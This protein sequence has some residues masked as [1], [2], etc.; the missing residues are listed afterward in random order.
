MTEYGVQ[1][2]KIISQYRQLNNLGYVISDDE[3]V[4]IMQKEMERTGKVYPG[5]EHLAKTT[6]AAKKETDNTYTPSPIAPAAQNV[7]GNGF[8]QGKDKGL[9]LEHTNTACATIQPTLIQLYT[10]NFLKNILKEGNAIVTDR[11]SEAGIMSGLVNLWQEKFN[12]E[13]S[14]SH[15]RKTLF[16]TQQDLQQME[17]AARGEPISTNFLGEPIYQTFEENFKS[18]RGVEFNAENITDCA[19]KSETYAQIKTAVEMVNKTKESLLTTTKGD[20]AS[21]MSPEESSKAIIQAFKLAGVT[22][23]NEIN[24]TLADINEKYKDHPDVLKYG[25]NFRIN[26]NKQGEY[27]IYRTDKSGYPAEATNEELRLIANEMSQRLDRTL[28]DA[29]GVEY[30]KDTTSEEMISL[31]QKKLKEYQDVYEESFKKA[32]GSRDLK[33]LSE[34][35]VA[36]Q[37]QGVATIEMGI[38]LL[39]TA[40][41]IL[42]PVAVAARGTALGA[43]LGLASKA[44]MG[45]KMIQGLETAQ[46]VSAPIVMAAMTLRPTELLEQISSQNGMSAEEWEAWGVGVLQNSVY[47]VTGMKVSQVA[48]QGAAMYKTKALVNTLKKAGKS[49]DE[50]I[51]M[52]KANP[53]KFPDDIV[54]SFKNI[55]KLAKTLQVTSEVALDLSSTYFLN[56]VMNNGDLQLQDWISSIAFAI[57]GGVLQKQFAPLTTAEKVQ[58]LC[59]AFKD[60][61]VTPNDAIN[62]LK[63][64]DDI[65]EGKI[66][67]PSKNTETNANDESSAKTN[68]QTNANLATQQNS[69]NASALED[70]VITVSRP[71]TREQVK[72][73]SIN[74]RIER[75]NSREEFVS[76]RDE[77]KNM[78]EGAEKKALQEEYLKKYNEW[79]Q[80]SQRPEIK[81]Q[82]TPEAS[83]EN[84]VKVLK[85]LGANDKQI[86]KFQENANDEIINFIQSRITSPDFNPQNENYFIYLKDFNLSLIQE[87]AANPQFPKEQLA[88]VA[89]AA[90]TPNFTNQLRNA[91]KNGVDIIPGCNR[92]IKIKEAQEAR[93][94]D[95]AVI[96]KQ[97]AYE[98]GKERIKANSSLTDMDIREFS[99]YANIREPAI[100]DL[101]IFCE[102]NEIKSYHNL[103]WRCSENRAGDKLT[104]EEI[105]ARVRFAQKGLENNLEPH[106]ITSLLF[107]YEK[108]SPE[109]MENRLNTEI[110]IKRQENEKLNAKETAIKN[111]KNSLLEKYNTPELRDVIEKIITKEN[112][113]EDL[114][115]NLD[116]IL[117]ENPNR[118]ACIF[119][120]KCA[121]EIK[122]EE[123]IIE[124]FKRDFEAGLK[125]P[126][127]TS[128]DTK[129]QS[130][131]KAK[132]VILTQEYLSSLK[133]EDGKPVFNKRAVESLITK[134]EKNPELVKEV[135]DMAVENAGL[136]APAVIE[137]LIEA[138]AIDKDMAFSIISMKK[139]NGEARFDML[140]LCFILSSFKSKFPLVKEAFNLEKVY[141]MDVDTSGLILRAENVTDI[142]TQF[143]YK[144]CRILE[145]MKKSDGSPMYHSYWDIQEGILQGL[146]D[147]P[148]L[149]LYYLKKNV[150][151]E[152]TAFDGDVIQA[153]NKIAQKTPDL[154]KAFRQELENIKNDENKTQRDNFISKIKAFSKI[155]NLDNALKIYENRE[156][157]GLNNTLLIYV[158][159]KSDSIPY[160]NIV[161]IKE[162][163][164]KERI[165]ELSP[166]D[167]FLAI[168][169]SHLA[170]AKSINEIPME[171]KKSLLRRLVATNTDLFNISDSLAK[172]FPL[173][174]RNQEQYCELLPALVRSLGIE[175]VKLTPQKVE[176]FNTSIDN[177]SQ[178]IAKIPDSDFANLH[179]TQEYSKDDFIKTVLEKVKDLPHIERQKVF[180]YYG[181]ELKA[182]KGNKNTGYSINGYPVNLNNGKK[183]AE[184]TDSKTQAVVESLREDVIR[185]TENNRIKCENPTVE[186]FLNEIVEDL[187]EIRTIIGKMQH[188]TH[189]YDVMQHSLKVM[190]KIAQ[191]PQFKTLNKSDQKIMLLASLMHDI[192]K[193]EGFSDKTHANNG[194]FDTFYIA[195]KFNLTSEEEIKLYTIIRH[196]EWLEHVNK[197]TNEYD[198]TKRLQSTA[199]D[200][201]QDNLFDMALIFTHADLKA[202]KYNNSFHDSTSG[203]INPRFNEE[204]RVFDNE[205]GTPISLGNAAD[206]YAKRIKIYINELK[207]SI[208]LTPVTQVP[209]SDVIK[210]HIK[211]INPDGST[212]HKGVYVDKDGL[213]VIKFNEVTDWEALGFPKGT[214][215][216]GIAGTGKVRDNRS[217]VIESEFDTGNFK[218]YAHAL[219]YAN[220][221]VKFDSFGLPDSDVLLSVTYMERPESKYRN[222]RTQGIGL[223]IKSKYVY[224]GG[225]TDAGSGC[226][227]TIKEFKDNYI[228]GGKREKDRVF[229][230]NLIKKATGMT[231]A[232]YIEFVTKNQ[233]K[234]W[235][236]IEPIDNS[237]PVEFRNKLI[238]AFG[239][240]IVSNQRAQ[241]RAYDEYYASNPEPPM[242]TWAY[243][244]DV[245]ETI[246]NPLDFLH[247][248]EMTEA[249]RK[250]GQVGEIMLTSV[251]ERTEFLR[252]YSLENNISFIVFGD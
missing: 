107:E 86:N 38:N 10:I 5:F 1:Q 229:T 134:G 57:S 228:F 172:D 125:K 46:K 144:Y 199:F 73:P 68:E 201:Q 58:Y 119:L 105:D 133:D 163:L 124:K 189:K 112:L 66:K 99:N 168:E 191:D 158:L 39:S 21:Q 87:I 193:R 174:P 120:E 148:E 24:K 15:V 127:L 64:M 18:R 149:T 204:E 157:L 198:L 241:K 213:V 41:M 71:S 31:T 250:I 154:E 178:T 70:V 14:K 65:S 49:T 200:L 6:S 129:W 67:V 207:K 211:R 93:M 243:S 30:S 203:I 59:D 247:R 78:A 179:I 34:E 26:K 195:K 42:P 173:I 151:D 96:A 121:S 171:A 128:G 175:T 138:A 74:E 164:G 89:N 82:N 81:M 184:I 23:V 208:P 182:N 187:P 8:Y 209:K 115:N 169:F 142:R 155:E 62:I 212:E 223:N 51:S 244:A 33:I 35:Y 103:L 141:D 131:P 218:F 101:I 132:E 85:Q 143:S 190:Q 194:S 94:N 40:L 113:P 63:T 111:K 37:Q 126:D 222:Y 196:H 202:V 7:F 186:K 237:D 97:K 165:S 156:E 159:E 106:E 224:G 197:S 29:I 36:K 123:F 160:E 72:E 116:A 11:D 69:K 100:Q 48:E 76:L 122:P 84:V 192:T 214:T 47:M 27:V 55:D 50:I 109:E 45:G 136:R 25:G 145:N 54:K 19:E 188:D 162:V 252:Q 226:G 61:G 251:E 91:Y 180:D 234:S 12:K 249:E 140:E 137:P 95:P 170:K 130:R 220:Q 44:S 219:N 152:R 92:V 205:E 230:A 22:S 79:S 147:N 9:S 32:Y 108:F 248:N 139:N 233:N 183:L 28:A 150:P 161:H 60:Y 75:A 240:N 239:E 4:S 118:A 16:K 232:E 227:K 167:A 77:I 88:L 3:V 206:I 231:D 185:F 235:N 104:S 215:T 17:K 166:K 13:Y 238:K 221:L 90:Y 53:V 153:I 102:K 56:I 242:F 83:K 114:L 216:S 43:K 20:V 80:S 236:E 181:F 110:D 52:V 98:E 117:G 146:I 246:N 135:V 210:S 177:L 2:Q 245:N 176:A 225:E 217:H